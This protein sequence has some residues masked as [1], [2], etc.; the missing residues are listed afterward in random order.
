MNSVNITFFRSDIL[1]DNPCSFSLNLRTIDDTIC[2][3]RQ[4]IK[5]SSDEG[6]GEC[7]AKNHL[8]LLISQ[9]SI[10][11]RKVLSA[12]NPEDDVVLKAIEGGKPILNAIVDTDMTTFLLGSAAMNVLKKALSRIDDFYEGFI[13]F[14]NL[15]DCLQEFLFNI[16]L[17]SHQD[18]RFKQDRK[19]ILE[20]QLTL[21]A[22]EI[23]LKKSWNQERAREKIGGSKSSSNPTVSKI[24][25]ESAPSDDKFGSI[26]SDGKLKKRGAETMDASE[27]EVVVTPI[28]RKRIKFARVSPKLD[29]LPTFKCHVCS[30]KFVWLKAL[31]RHLKMQHDVEEVHGDLKEVDDKVTCRICKT[32]HS[33][34]LLTRH[35][36]TKHKIEKL[37]S[38]SVFRGFL[39]VNGLQWQPLW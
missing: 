12:E 30:K 3:F 11:T 4:T 34:D 19:Q 5:M 6:G 36:K 15:D 37:G 9:C 1:N 2:Y 23:E 13:E 20:V 27:S 24:P 38:K 39:T 18:G 32:K 8:R 7:L 33:R 10:L 26:N 14:E 25:D 29:I 35:L 28:A 16:Q 31:K 22:L 17:F 21:K